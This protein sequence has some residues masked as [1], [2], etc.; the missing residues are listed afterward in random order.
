MEAQFTSC[1]V[2][3]KRGSTDQRITD[4]NAKVVWNHPRNSEIDTDH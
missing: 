1:A 3:G 2:S 4:Y